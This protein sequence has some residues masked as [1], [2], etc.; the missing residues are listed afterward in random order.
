V[1]D[2][3]IVWDRLIW[4]TAGLICVAELLC[5]VALLAKRRG[6]L[7]AVALLLCGFVGVLIYGIAIGLD[8]HCGCL[9]VGARWSLNVQLAIDIGLLLWCILIHWSCKPCTKNQTQTVIGQSG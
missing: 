9:S 8:I 4:P 2:F 5:G 7:L 6:S 3:G 1:G